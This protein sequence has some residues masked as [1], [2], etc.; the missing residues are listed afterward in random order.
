MGSKTGIAA[1]L[2]LVAAV[3]SYLLSFSGRPIWALFAAIISVPLGAVGLVMA[4][5]PRVSGGIMSIIAMVLG[6]GGVILAVLVLVG[7]ILF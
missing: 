6:V 7:M 1:I 4:A 3:G 5:S 2:A